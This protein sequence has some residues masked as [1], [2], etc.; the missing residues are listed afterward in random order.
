MN[1]ETV[2]EFPPGVDR[3]DINARLDQALSNADDPPLSLV[4]EAV[5]EPDDR[6][7][8]RLVVHA[9]A[10]LAD[11]RGAETAVPAAAAIEL[12]RGY[13][14]LRS[15][16]LVQPTD[17]CAHTLTPEPTR[18]LLAGDYLYT[19]AYSTLHLQA[20]PAPKA[21][22]EVLTNVLETVT[23]AFALVDGE[24]ASPEHDQTLF[25]DRTAGSIGG[26]AARLGATLAGAPESH[27]AKMEQIGHGLSTARQ[28]RR[29]RN[30]DP[31]EAMVVPPTTD[32]ASLRKHAKKQH[33][34][35]TE[36]VRA[37]S[38]AVDTSFVQRFTVGDNRVNE[39]PQNETGL[40]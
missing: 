11:V 8:G 2:P 21:C 15:R 36:A 23:E 29:I 35:A 18:A 16:L 34:E 13:T 5:A 28:I 14:R 3:A 24:T 37:L 9:Y 32:D 6:W 19:T 40:D 10:S 25:F 12:L 26:G 22:L 39:V 7:Y 31:L 1:D 4:R 33:R 20:N 30:A 38:P 17:T 27:R